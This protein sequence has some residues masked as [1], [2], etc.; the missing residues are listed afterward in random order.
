MKLEPV[1]QCK[2]I[3]RKTSGLGFSFRFLFSPFSRDYKILMVGFGFAHKKK[4][5]RS[6]ALSLQHLLSLY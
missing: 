5:E 1:S 4:F 2:L 6:S 3:I